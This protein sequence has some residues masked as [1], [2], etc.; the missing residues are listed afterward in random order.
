M[1]LAKIIEVSAEGETIETAVDNA[2]AEASKSVRGIS[3]VNVENIKALVSDDR[4]TTYR[5]LCKISFVI[6]NEA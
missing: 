6:D 4:V 5:V 2:V 3:A 1:A